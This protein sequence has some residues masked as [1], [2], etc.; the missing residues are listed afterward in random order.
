MKLDIGFV[1]INLLKCRIYTAK[2]EIFAIRFEQDKTNSIQL[3]KK[4]I[5]NGKRK[6]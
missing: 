4:E 3:T 2:K 6:F 1:A 5:K